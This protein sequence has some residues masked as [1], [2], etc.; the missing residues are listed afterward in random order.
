MT[1]LPTRKVPLPEADHICHRRRYQ[2]YSGVDSSCR[3]AQPQEIDR[4]SCSIERRHDCQ[5]DISGTSSRISCS[6]AAVYDRYVGMSRLGGS[7]RTTNCHICFIRAFGAL[8][9]IRTGSHSQEQLRCVTLVS[10]RR[11]CPFHRPPQTSCDGM[12]T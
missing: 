4:I 9:H 8:R 12:E 10:L 5:S 2:G 11:F 6:Q 7:S 3:Q 1:A